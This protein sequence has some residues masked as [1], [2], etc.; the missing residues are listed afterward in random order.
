V[1]NGVNK[2]EFKAVEP[3]PKGLKVILYVGRLEEYKGVQYAIHALKFLPWYRL[4]VIGRG[5]Y[6][7]ALLEEAK[8]AGVQ[9]RVAI[10]EG[11][12]RG[13]LLRW[14]A[15]ADVFV[16]LS[17][18]EAYGITVAEALTA[19][20]PSIVANGSALEEFVD[21]DTCKGVDLPIDGEALAKLIESAQFKE[22]PKSV[23]DWDQVAGMVLGIYGGMQ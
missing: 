12:S 17:T 11:Q 4:L 13:N 3:W 10:L 19:G 15:T 7:E 2:A 23:L 14:Y 20:V 1:P 16:M 6:K 18:S 9:D 5:P 8:K 21:G 22:L